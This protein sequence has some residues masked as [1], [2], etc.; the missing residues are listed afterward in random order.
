MTANPLK[1]QKQ[2][3]MNI[4]ICGEAVDRENPSHPYG[5]SI[6]Q[7]SF[8]IPFNYVSFATQVLFPYR[9]LERQR[10]LVGRELAALLGAVGTI[11]TSLAPFLRDAA[12]TQCCETRPKATIST[13]ALRWAL[14]WWGRA[15]LVLHSLLRTGRIVSLLWRVG[16]LVLSL[17]RT[18]LLL[19]RLATTIVSLV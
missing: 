9:D 1:L 4:R 14:L 15:L 19:L 17:G 18:I 2:E 6:R 7:A 16:L 8:F 13:L 11:S 5:T 3:S 10:M 12:T